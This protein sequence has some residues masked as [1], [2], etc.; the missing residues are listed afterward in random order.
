MKQKPVIT[1]ITPVTES[2]LFK[3]EDV[4]L[5]YSNGELRQHERLNNGG[6]GV[7]VVMP[8]DQSHVYLVY[9]YAAGFGRYELGFVKGKVD[10]GEDNLTAAN[11]ELQEEIGFA[12]NDIHFVREVTTRPHYSTSKSSL[13]IAQ[14]LYPSQLAGDEPEQLQL[15]K[16]PLEKIEGLFQHPDITEARTLCALSYLQQFLNR[17]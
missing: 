17:K 11:R 14:D 1:A 15:V 6:Y 4:S 2:R 10:K 5:R 13:L 16:W 9:E 3:V 12:S 8:I 7:V